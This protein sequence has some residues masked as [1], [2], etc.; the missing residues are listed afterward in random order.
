MI[1]VFGL[2]L[3]HVF[4]IAL[5]IAAAVVLVEQ[6]RKH[7]VDPLLATVRAWIVK[8]ITTTEAAAKKNVVVP[9]EDL[10]AHAKTVA[11]QSPI[12]AAI[13]VQSGDNTVEIKPPATPAAPANMPVPLDPVQAVKQYIAGG[14]N[15]EHGMPNLFNLQWLLSLAVPARFAWAVAVAAAFDAQLGPLPVTARSDM[16]DDIGTLPDEPIRSEAKAYLT[17]V[18]QGFPIIGVWHWTRQ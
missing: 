1:T 11:L 2:S 4:L 12:G 18:S 17:N 9:L 3:L 10:V 15:P 6:A 5:V 7:G 13:F 16:A 14:M 8:M